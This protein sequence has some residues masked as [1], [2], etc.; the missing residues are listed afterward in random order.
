MC[1]DLKRCAAMNLELKK[2]NVSEMIF[3]QTRLFGNQTIYSKTH[4][5]APS[6][7]YEFAFIRALES[8]LFCDR[9]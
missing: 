5:F 3:S 4:G 7:P 1:G 6:Y 2:L 9:E 8:I